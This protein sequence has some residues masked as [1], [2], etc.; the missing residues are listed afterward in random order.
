MDQFFIYFNIPFL[1]IVGNFQR[2]V[3][4]RNLVLSNLPTASSLCRLGSDFINLLLRPIAERGMY[5]SSLVYFFPST[6]SRGLWF[7]DQLLANY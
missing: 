3:E 5:K 6:T 7:H 1:I 4:R 2:C